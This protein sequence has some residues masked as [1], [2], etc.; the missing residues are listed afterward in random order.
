MTD[1]ATDDAQLTVTTHEGLGDPTLR[2]AW[3]VLVDADPTASLFQ[4]ARW[5]GRW[6]DVLAGPRALRV[7]AFH[8][9]DTLVGLL[10]ETRELQ[11]LPSGPQE[12]LRLAGGDE[13]TD[14][15][16]PVCVPAHRAA[17][18]R[19][20]V[21][22]LVE[23]RG[24]DEAVL[25]GLPEDTGWHE[26][27]AVAAVDA[28]LRV[29]D[30]GVED[31]CPRVDLAGGRDAYQSGLP[32]RLRQ[33][34][35]RKA[36]KLARDVGDYAVH[37]YAPD[38]TAAGIED[39]LAQV[40]LPDDDKASFFRRAEMQQ[41][42]RTLAEEYAADGTLRVHRLDAGGLP[43]AMTVSL[44][45][46]D[47]GGSPTVWGLYNSSFDPTLAALSPGVVL[48]WELIGQAADEG[49][50]VFDLLRGDEAYKYRFGAV[51]R[52]VRTLTLT[53]S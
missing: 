50:T 26:L 16:G 13:V 23:E 46:R 9:G 3:D 51:D 20:Y 32:G 24:W 4:R 48:V 49:F 1:P 7:R 19:A 36:R 52:P 35:F 41:W 6:D 38:A 53:R 28:G 14:Y 12:L 40:V 39:F 27:I 21:A 15:L 5:L 2:A 8:A 42:F 47:A 29:S 11:R 22:T 30:A 25:T 45:D 18:A 31:V 17:V 44:L 43:A 37:T 10:A 33:E 34:M